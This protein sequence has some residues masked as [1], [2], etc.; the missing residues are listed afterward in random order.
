MPAPRKA[1]TK[2]FQ[3]PAELALERI[4]PLDD[5]EDVAGVS[6]ETLLKEMP[7]KILQLSERRR[8]IRLKHALRLA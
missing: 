6:K 7:D 4:V 2:P 3:L 8:G 1:K 5:A